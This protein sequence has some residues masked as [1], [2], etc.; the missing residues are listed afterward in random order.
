[1]NLG[2]GN[3]VGIGMF[4]FTFVGLTPLIFE[5]LGFSL[6]SGILITSILLGIL[7][8]IILYFSD[9]QMETEK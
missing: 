5:E 8:P 3:Y 7:V 1:M 4:L 9:K 6:E 2:I